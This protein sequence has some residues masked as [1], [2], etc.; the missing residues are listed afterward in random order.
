MDNERR[1]E[2]VLGSEPVDAG[3]EILAMRRLAKPTSVEIFRHF[4]RA[5]NFNLFDQ[6]NAKF[7]SWMAESAY[8]GGL[9]SNAIGMR[10]KQTGR[11]HGIVR[12]YIPGKWLT[13]GL[14]IDG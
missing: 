1:T 9:K 8:S 10:H 2:E 4:A 6:E 3:P 11:V 12:A 14:A 7:E 13:E 5:Q